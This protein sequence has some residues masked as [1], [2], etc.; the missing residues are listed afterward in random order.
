MNRVGDFIITLFVSPKKKAFEL[1]NR[2]IS[3]I[4]TCLTKRLC[5]AQST[6]MDVLRY[7]DIILHYE[8]AQAKRGPTII[9]KILGRD[10]SLIEYYKSFH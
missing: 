3:C 8:L 2:N 1:E 4:G 6:L 5:V 7:F 9:F 10:I